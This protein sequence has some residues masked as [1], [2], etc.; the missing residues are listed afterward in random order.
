MVTLGKG[1]AEALR[2]L[3][4]VGLVL[5]FT[6]GAISSA[7]KVTAEVRFVEIAS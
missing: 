6:T 7:A 5:T 4:A 2:S 3:A 1:L